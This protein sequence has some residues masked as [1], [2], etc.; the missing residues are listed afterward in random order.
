MPSCSP[1]LSWPA[2]HAWWADYTDVIP[3]GLET[4]LG[5][6]QAASLIRGYDAQFVP[7]LLQSRDYARTLIEL[8]DDTLTSWDVT[9]Q[10]ELRMKRQQVL[11]REDPVRLWVILDEAVLRRPFGGRETMRGQLQYLIDLASLPNVTIQVLRFGACGYTADG[12]FAV[13]RFLEKEL[14]DMVFVEHVAGA[15][16]YDK[17]ADVNR[18]R[19][20]VNRLTVLAEQPEATLAILEEELR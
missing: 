5:F 9:R 16:H 13:L 10:V 12:S 14:P 3:A 20:A 15:C 11:L 6:E 8:T 4:Y 18:Y 17:P 1:W 19:D 7:A 2:G